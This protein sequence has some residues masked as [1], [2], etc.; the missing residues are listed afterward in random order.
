MRSC[1]A[2]G[3][4]LLVPVLLMGAEGAPGA[5]VPPATKAAPGAPAIPEPAVV[6][7]TTALGAIDL[8]ID[9]ARAP[10]SAA[11]F[12]R[13]VDAGLYDGSRFHRTVR[14]DN[15]TR[16]D[17]AI[18]VVQAGIPPERESEGFAPIPLERT[19]ATGLQHL[20]GTLSM[21]RDGADTATSDFFICIGDQPGLDFGG[22]RQPDGQGFAAFGQVLRGMEIVRRIHASHADGQTLHP[23]IAILTA[24]RIP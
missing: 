8:A 17:V 22:A 1:V 13:Y 7:L 6:R 16:K 23:P 20:D 24:R 14:P 21:A 5:Q 9:V 18:E 3:L 11:N 4:F 10:V 19:Q 15:E 2:A 12:L